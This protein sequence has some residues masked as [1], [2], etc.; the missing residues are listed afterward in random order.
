MIANKTAIHQRPKNEDLNNYR[1][2]YS[3]QQGAKPLPYCSK[4]Y[5]GYEIVGINS[6]ER[7]KI[8]TILISAKNKCGRQ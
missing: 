2:L 1:S 4:L 8:K 5:L 3:F 7:K 6:R